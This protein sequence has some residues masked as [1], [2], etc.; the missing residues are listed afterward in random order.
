MLESLRG[1]SVDAILYEH[2]DLA[3]VHPLLCP[4]RAVPYFVFLHGVEVWKSLDPLRRVSLLGATGLL[5]NSHF[6]LK[7]A[8]AHN[9]WLPKA[10]VVWLATTPT[11]HAESLPERGPTAVMVGRMARAERYKGHDAV[12]DAWVHVRTEI[13]NARLII[14]GSGDD[15]RRLRA[16]V[17]LEE[18]GG[19]EFTGWVSEEKKSE[20]VR[21]ARLALLPSLREGFG[22]AALEALALGVPV[23]GLRG[24]VLGEIAAEGQGAVLVDSQDDKA[25]ADKMIEVLRSEE[26][27]RQLG[28]RGRR[29]V[30]KH[31]RPEHFRTRLWDAVAPSLEQA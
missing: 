3:R 11:P 13:P 28:D 26:R 17:R 10:K 9:P 24:S 4:F 1:R 29:H 12:L 6:T 20:I 22:L 7:L 19:V 15:E 25:L 31:F 21:T 27:S 18:V 30:E 14:V 8:R 23:L 2:V 5:T 16:R